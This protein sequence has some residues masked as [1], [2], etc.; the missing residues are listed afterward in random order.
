MQV[1]LAPAKA[2][3]NFIDPRGLKGYIGRE[4]VERPEVEPGTLESRVRRSNHYTTSPISLLTLFWLTTTW[5]GTVVSSYYQKIITRDLL[6]NH[7]GET[8]LE[9]FSE[10]A[11]Y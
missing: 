9:K 4:H 7:R 5:S 2:G 3:I 8:N 1:P 11:R 6:I 10:D